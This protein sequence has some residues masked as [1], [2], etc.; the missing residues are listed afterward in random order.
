MPPITSA[1]S[2]GSTSP[3]QPAR[4]DA[5][6]LPNSPGADRTRDITLDYYINC[7]RGGDQIRSILGTT[8]RYI[9]DGERVN[10]SSYTTNPYSTSMDLVACGGKVVLEITISRFI[11][12]GTFSHGE[13][14]YELRPLEAGDRA[15]LEKLD[16]YPQNH[17]SAKPVQPLRFQFQ[18][19]GVGLVGKA[20]LCLFDLADHPFANK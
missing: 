4:S 3:A 2:F 18:D 5:P 6:Y 10:V 13:K 16:L 11:W 15:K 20:S 14:G 8:A 17:E 12:S 19:S 1:T 9:K 7:Q